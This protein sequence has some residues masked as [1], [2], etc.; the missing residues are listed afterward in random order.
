[1]PER[2]EWGTREKEDFTEGFGEGDTAG[3]M[4]GDYFA[5]LGSKREK[6]PKDDAP[7]PEKVHPPLLLETRPRALRFITARHVSLRAQ[8]ADLRRIRQA[9]R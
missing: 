7:N 2:R 8:Q 1:M 4:G 6:K 9:Q 5:S 3:V